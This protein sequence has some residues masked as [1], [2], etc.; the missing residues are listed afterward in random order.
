MIKIQLVKPKD[1]IAQEN[2][3]TKDLKSLGPKE[4]IFFV[5][6]EAPPRDNETKDLL[7]LEV[8]LRRCERVGFFD[9]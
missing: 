3:E 8:A 1:L 9:R 4:V 2:I 6:G 7:D 5:S